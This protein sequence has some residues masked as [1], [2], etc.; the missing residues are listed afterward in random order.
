MD[1]HNPATE[2]IAIK[3]GAI[4]AIGRPCRHRRAQ[5]TGHAGSSTPRAARSCPASSKPHA[6]VRRRRRARP[7]ASLR[8]PRLRCLADAVR[9]LR[10]AQPER[11]AAA[12]RRAPTTRSCPKASGSPA[13]I[14][15]ASFADR[16]FAM[17]ASDHHTMWANTKALEQ[18]GLLHGK[19]LGPGNEIVMGAD[20]LAAG[21]L[22]E[23][24]AFGPLLELAGRDRDAARPGDRRRAGSLPVA[25]GAG[26]RP[27]HHA[28][29]P[30]MVRP[31]R[32]HLDP[33][34][35]RQSLPARAAGRDRKPRA[36]CFAGRKIPF[37]FKNFMT[38]D[39]LDKASRMAERLQFRMALL[40]HRQG[41]L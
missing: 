38:L 12:R 22:R 23:I 33:E 6:P 8:R 29:R 27:R 41:L 9:D 5:G 1:D 28:A 13:M 26:R 35:G 37:H 16:P 14:S 40:R 25:D 15:T 34:H 10:G 24:E 19:K 4:I 21:E 3:D 2:A 17:A 36:S 30:A 31:P 39:M 20:G 18:A 32:H 7:S 11:Q